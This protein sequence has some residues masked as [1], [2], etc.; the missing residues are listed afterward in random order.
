MHD[1]SLALTGGVDGHV[2][3]AEHVRVLVG[4]RVLRLD[5]SPNL[6]GWSVRTFAGAGWAF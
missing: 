1:R 6:R 2:R 4:A 5:L 3:V